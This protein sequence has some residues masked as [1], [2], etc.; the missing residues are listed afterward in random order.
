MEILFR[1]DH[2]TFIQDGEVVCIA[3]KLCQVPEAIFDKIDESDADSIMDF[4]L[5]L[6]TDF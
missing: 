4:F 3:Y 1:K 5:D 2:L 6:Q